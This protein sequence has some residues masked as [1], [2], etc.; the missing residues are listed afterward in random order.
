MNEDYPTDEELDLIKNWPH[1]SGFISLMDK[2]HELWWAPDWG[3]HEEDAINDYE[4][5]IIRYN[6]STGGWSGNEDLIFALKS[7][8]FFWGMGWCSSRKG[9]HYVFELPIEV[10]K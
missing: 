3:W 10:N 9:G 8:F 4:E 6:I 2:V 7:N 5:S 1:E